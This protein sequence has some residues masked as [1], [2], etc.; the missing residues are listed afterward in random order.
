MPAGVTREQQA[1]RDAEQ[2]I[3]FADGAEE[4]GLTV[5]ARRARVVAR[6]TIWLATELENARST[7]RA[8]KQKTDRMDDIL[9]ERVFCDGCRQAMRQ[10]ETE[11][12]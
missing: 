7:N 9:A 3:V 12:A 8:L 2:L 4:A 1:A 10:T 11:A 6:E 5:Y